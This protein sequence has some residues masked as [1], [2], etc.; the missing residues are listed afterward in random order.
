MVNGVDLLATRL[1]VKEGVLTGKIAG[2]N[3]HGEE[4]VRRIKEAYPKDA[5]TKVYAY[6]D[7]KGDLPML[8]LADI[9]F[10]KPFR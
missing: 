9:R 6:G 5:L 4:K 10:Y 3:C 2:V 1:E 8:R 7:T